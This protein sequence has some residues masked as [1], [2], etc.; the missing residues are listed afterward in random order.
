MDNDNNNDTPR[1]FDLGEAIEE[2]RK[3]SERIMYNNSN[4][5]SELKN[6][7][8]DTIGSLIDKLI[9]A[10]IKIY[11]AEDIKRDKLASDKVIADATRLTNKLN[12]HR[13]QLITEIDNLSGQENFNNIKSYGKRTP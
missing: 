12:Q 1:I 4:L 2:W 6:K 3:M 11:M 9:I 10:N 13:N 7:Q 5:G 8:M